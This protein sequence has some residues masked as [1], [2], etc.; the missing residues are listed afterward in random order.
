MKL[1]IDTLRALIPSVSIGSDHSVHLV[2]RTVDWQQHHSLVMSPDEAR[3]IAAKLLRAA[4]NA[5][6]RESEAQVPVAATLD[7]AAA[8]PALTLDVAR[9]LLRDAATG[10]RQLTARA[11]SE[12]DAD[13]LN[14][15]M[16]E[17]KPV[18]PEHAREALEDMD[19]YAR[20]DAGVDAKGPRETLER[21]IAEH[22]RVVADAERY[23]ALCELLRRDPAAPWA[24]RELAAFRTT[25]WVTGFKQETLDR[26]LDA[27]IA[28]RG[29]KENGHE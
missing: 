5:I 9:E 4:A 23:R 17:M 29:A 2:L 1:Y 26:A 25:Q 10:I 27:V 14:K 20:M 28:A 18:T 6:V 12:P 24:L 11:T 21:F 7:D 15:P 3:Y 19:D 16:S 22:E 8:D 13:T